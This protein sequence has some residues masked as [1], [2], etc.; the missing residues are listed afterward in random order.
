MYCVRGLELCCTEYKGN[1]GCLKSSAIHKRQCVVQAILYGQEL[2]CQYM[3][4]TKA[5]TDYSIQR[6]CRGIVNIYWIAATTTSAA[7]QKYY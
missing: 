2:Q 5:Q 4:V 1:L 3:E 7:H 6:I